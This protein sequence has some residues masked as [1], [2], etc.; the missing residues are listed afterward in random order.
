MKQDTDGKRD[1]KESSYV[2]IKAETS[3]GQLRSHSELSLDLNPLDLGVDPEREREIL[4][5][6]A[7]ARH[8]QVH[9]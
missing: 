1:E 8:M 5:Y 9:V 6:L 3:V 2:Q 7:F 4:S